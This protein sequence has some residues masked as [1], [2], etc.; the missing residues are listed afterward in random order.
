MT[1]KIEWIDTV[2]FNGDSIIKL[3]LEY[4][5]KFVD[6]FYICEQ[7]YTHQGN[8]KEILYIEKYSEWFDKYRDK[9]VFLVDEECPDSF[10]LKINIWEYENRHRNF[11]VPF[12]L[13]NHNKFICTVCDCDE[14]P[15]REVILKNI[16]NLYD[17]S[18]TGVVKLVQDFLYYNFDWFVSKWARAFVISDVLLR[19]SNQ[20]QIYR[21][22]MGQI[23]NYIECGWHFSYFM[24]P[25]EIVRKLESIADTI[26]VNNPSYVMIECKNKEHI[27]KCINEGYDLFK[28]SN[29]KFTPYDKS[30]L[31]QE[32]LKYSYILYI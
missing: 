17:S 26:E 31:P 21:D 3:R 11:S 22:E 19:E 32:F 9:I 1:D 4:L 18:K 24:S 25:D 8:R 2:M 16:A 13:Q 12:I 5:Y 14:I 20:F 10:Y 7:R 29:Q 6:K 28:R 27:I 30:K 15:E 23:N